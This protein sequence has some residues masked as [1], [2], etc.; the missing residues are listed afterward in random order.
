MT[1]RLHKFLLTQKKICFKSQGNSMLP[2]L[3]DNDQI[4][5]K[6]VRFSQIIVNDL[7]LIKLCRRLI[8]HR[9]IYKTP[10]YLITKGDNNPQ[11]DG[12]VYSRQIIGKVVKIK[13][14]SRE[15]TP[16]S[17]YLI[18]STHYLQEIEKINTVFAKKKLDYLFL[19]GLPLHLYYEKSHPCRIY[20]D[21]DV[22]MTPRSLSA[23]KAILIK[24]GYKQANKELSSGLKKIKSYEPELV[25]YKKLKSGFSVTF[26]L[27]QELVFQM[28]E[29]G[30]IESF[31]SPRLLGRL[32]QAVLQN[33]R[34]IKL[35]KV[36]Y[37]ILSAKLLIIYL[38]LHLFHHNFEGA[39]RYAFLEKVLNKESG[40]ARFSWEKLTA[41]IKNYQ[42]QSFV[43]PVFVLLKKHYSPNLPNRVLREVKPESRFQ[44]QVI[45]KIVK[46]TDIFSSEP[47]IKAGIRRFA[48]LFLLSP[49]PLW[50]RVLVFAQPSVLFSIFW[51]V[52]KRL[53]RR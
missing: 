17:L 52:K 20:A 23:A 7:I 26:D 29:L 3:L 13:R 19:K 39:F 24:Q 31:Y 32:N 6:K 43:Y 2:L 33:R 48:Y 15:F 38:A 51:V 4:F 16:E 45:S 18:Q 21:C 37:P 50:K 42:L 22:L 36:S 35:N 11:S 8:T 34:F 10:K 44:Q 14:G 9:V 41:L 49:Q 46:N 27:H 53:F 1:S 12:R 28:T 47:R 25:F 5:L 30:K 40:K